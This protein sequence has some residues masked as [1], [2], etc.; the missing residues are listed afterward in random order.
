[1]YNIRKKDKVSL[2]KNDSGV[3]SLLFCSLVHCIPKNTVNAVCRI[4]APCELVM[5]LS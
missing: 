3:D 1:M 4:G 2:H 5:K